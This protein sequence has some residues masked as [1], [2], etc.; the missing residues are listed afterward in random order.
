MNAKGFTLLQPTNMSES[1]FEQIWTSSAALQQISYWYKLAAFRMPL[2][3]QFY[4]R[5]PQVCDV[6]T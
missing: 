6:S 2:S 1:I 3:L 5:D 4:V